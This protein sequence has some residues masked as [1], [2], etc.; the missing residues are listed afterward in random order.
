MLPHAFFVILIGGTGKARRRGDRRTGLPDLLWRRDLELD[1]DLVVLAGHGRRASDDAAALQR[2]V[3]RRRSELARDEREWN[4]PL[5]TT[6]GDAQLG[7]L[8]VVRQLGKG[9]DV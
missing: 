8:R 5:G 6:V 3:E 4:T 9:D 7:A 2:H 1:D